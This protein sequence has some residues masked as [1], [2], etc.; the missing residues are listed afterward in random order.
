MKKLL[1]IMIV[2]LVVSVPVFCQDTPKA[3]VFGGYQY[4]R[5]NPGSGISGENFNGWNAALTGN[6]NHWLGVT[7][8]FSGA[9]K[10][11]SGVSLK[12]HTFMFGPTISSHSSDKFTPF[13]HALFGGAHFSG[14]GF[15]GSASDTAFAMALG[16]GVDVG[17]KNFA[18]RIGQFDYLMTRF[19]GTS[20]NNFRYSAGIVFRFGK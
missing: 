14:S 15:G 16:G 11:I 10:T 6:L 9:Y 18:V 5:I 3:E 1:G 19:G 17:V 8:D 2:L 20:Q 12:Q 7:G 13:A 4:T